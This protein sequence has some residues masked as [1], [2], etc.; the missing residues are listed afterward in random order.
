MDGLYGAHVIGK[1]YYRYVCSQFRHLLAI[2]LHTAAAARAAVSIHGTVDAK[3]IDF[4]L[5]PHQIDLV[6]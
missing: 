6:G 4:T 5:R 1:P 2:W 3:R